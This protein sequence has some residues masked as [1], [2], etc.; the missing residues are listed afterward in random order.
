METIAVPKNLPASDDHSF[1]AVETEIVELVGAAQKRGHD[2]LEN[3]LTGFRQRLIDLDFE[4]RFADVKALSLA[5]LGDL[6]AEWESG[7]D[8]LST[9]RRD[10]KD[11]E[12]HYQ[13]FSSQTR[14]AKA[15]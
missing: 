6:K 7:L 11:H 1:D 9:R 3:H 13:D 5:G 4:A 10:L 14:P 2:Q 8:E 15:L 12:D